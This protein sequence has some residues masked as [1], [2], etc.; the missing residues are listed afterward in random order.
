[1]KDPDPLESILLTAMKM[2]DITLTMEVDWRKA[3]R[4]RIDLEYRELSPRGFRQSLF[5]L[6]GL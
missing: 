6:H 5:Q 3:T 4:S 1:M 2:F